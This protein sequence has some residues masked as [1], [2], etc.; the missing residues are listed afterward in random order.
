MKN[1]IL[2]LLLPSVLFLGSCREDV[3]TGE[4]ETPLPPDEVPEFYELNMTGRVVDEAGQGIADAAVTIGSSE[5][6]TDAYGFYAVDGVLA[7]ETGLYIRATK[8]GYF[9]GGTQHNPVLD[10]SIASAEAFI[11][12]AAYTEMS[13]FDSG[14]GVFWTLQD[15][16]SLEIPADAFTREGEPYSGS[17][18]VNMKWLDP[19]APQTST[20]MPGALLGQTLSGELQLLQT[21]GM[22]GVEMSDPAGQPL[23]IAEGQ[24]A[25]LKFPLPSGL[26]SDAPNEIPLWHFDEQEGVWIEEGSATKNG[27]EYIG[28]VSHFTWWNCDV[29]GEYTYLCLNFFD[30]NGDPV[31]NAE[32]CIVSTTWG[33][34]SGELFGSNTVCNLAPANENLTLSM[35]DNCGDEYFSVDLGSFPEGVADQDVSVISQPT[36]GTMTLSGTLLDCSNNPVT[37]GFVSVETG[38][39]TFS[40]VSIDNGAYSITFTVCDANLT[41]ATVIGVDLND[42]KE[43]NP[44][45]ITFDYSL[46]SASLDITA[47]DAVIEASLIIITDAGE[48][49]EFST[50]EARVTYKEILITADDSNGPNDEQAV[51]GVQGFSVGVHDANFFGSWSSDVLEGS[52]DGFQIEIT[53]YEDVGGQIIGSFTHD[54]ATGTFIADRIQ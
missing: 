42:L 19:T 5:V 24:T 27:N 22:L 41:E 51:I 7:P 8:E 4:T 36:L 39:G 48:V 30:E 1:F 44:Q 28:E 32:Y 3:M 52:A 34:A 18:L 49:L 26:A 10:K 43:S 2:L 53:Q 14:I 35:K 47:C 29:P 9:V 40:D 16:S 11:T 54:G 37:H 45:P 17:V 31:T 50:C 38:Y 33:T 46:S 20:L 23:Q 12:L 13:T 21:F 6:V 25:T 15:G